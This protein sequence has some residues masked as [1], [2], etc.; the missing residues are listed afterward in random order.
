MTAILKPCGVWIMATIFA[1]FHVRKRK[2]SIARFDVQKLA[3]VCNMDYI[4]NG[5][6]TQRFRVWMVGLV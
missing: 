3:T 1:T 6:V 4:N 5:R 2:A